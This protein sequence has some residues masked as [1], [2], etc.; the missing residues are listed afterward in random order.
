[1][2]S[3]SSGSTS[4]AS[5][6]TRIARCGSARSNSRITTSSRGVPTPPPNLP[7][8]RCYEPCAASALWVRMPGGHRLRDA[9]L[10]Q[11][12]DGPQELLDGRDGRELLLR[13]FRPQPTLKVRQTPLTE[14]KFPVVDVHTHFRIRTQQSPEALDEFVRDHGSQSDRDLREPRRRPRGSLPR[15]C[16]VSLEA[17]RSLRD[18][19]EYRLAGFGESGRTGDVGLPAT[20]FRSHDD[21]AAAQSAC[22]GGGGGEDL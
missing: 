16:R 11:P 2:N 13:H 1:M 3:L 14:A 15:A 10:A 8:D 7:S 21:R 19:R 17:C 5:R 6:E 20:R 22:V 18:L 4:E 9:L 12:A